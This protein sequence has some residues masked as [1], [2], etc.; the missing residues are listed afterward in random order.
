MSDELTRVLLVEDDPAHAELV[1]RAFAM[2]D[3]RVEL[4]VAETLG[5]ARG[6]LA[7][8]PGLPHLVISDWRLPDGEGMEL[9]TDERLSDVPVIIMTS[10][11]NERLAVGALKA[12]ALDYVVKSETTLLDMPHIAER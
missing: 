4:H 9:L 12:G 10:Q 7:E 6:C 8:P 5:E 3:R 1:R 11:G 2:R